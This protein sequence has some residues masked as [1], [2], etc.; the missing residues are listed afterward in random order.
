MSAAKPLTPRGRLYV[1]GVIAIGAAVLVAAVIDLPKGPDGYYLDW[2]LL[3]ALTAISGSAT[4][5]LPSIP[6]SLSV[7]ETFVFTSVL[8]FGPPAGTLTVALDGLIIS[9]WLSK[10]RKEFHRILF[11]VAA[12]AIS[13]WVASHVFF[14][15]AGIQPLSV[16]RKGS[17]DWRLCGPAVGVHGTV[18]RDQQL[19]DCVC[20][21]PRN[22]DLSDSDLAHKFLVALAEL[23]LRGG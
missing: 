18:L 2:L 23:F 16:R 11:N 8:L 7:S 19:D 10:N 13:I 12:P 15:L 5:K 21:R 3:A 1:H 22:Q 14:Y 4:V 9:L 17:T 20:R 6:A